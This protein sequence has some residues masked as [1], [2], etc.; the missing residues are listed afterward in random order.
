[1]ENWYWEYNHSV[2]VLKV[3]PEDPAAETL[4]VD[5][6]ITEQA[7]FY[8]LGVRNLGA[9]YDETL[10]MRYELVRQDGNWLV[11]TMDKVD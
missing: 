7:N 10:T 8:E 6:K 9:S 4:T 2:E 1:R 11:K 3:D 5:A